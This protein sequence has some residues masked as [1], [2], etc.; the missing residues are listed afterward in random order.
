M[1]K[2][3]HTGSEPISPYNDN[4]SSPGYEANVKRRNRI[5]FVC[6][7]CRRSKTKCDREKPRCGRCIQHGLPC[8]YDVEK[9][10]APRN[11]SKD[12]TISR[13]EKD[14]EY[15]KA[16]ALGDRR[17]DVISSK[18]LLDANVNEVEKNGTKKPRNVNSDI[19]NGSD[20]IQINLYKAHPSMIMNRVM[21]R[22]VKPLSENYA[23]TQDAFLSGLIASVFL[24]PSKNTM[25]PA[26]TASASVSR[27]QP[28]V[29]DNVFKLKEILIRQCHNASQVSRIN[30][31]TDRILQNTNSNRNLR[32]GMMP[33][34]NQ[35]TF[36]RH[37]MEDFC[38]KTGEYSDLL[39]DFIKEMESILPPFDIIKN[40]KAHFY[41]NVFPDLPF[42]NRYLFEESLALTLYPDEDN[43]SKVKIR[44]GNS[45]LRTKMENLSILLVILK[46]SYIS[47]RLMEEGSE[48]F[49]F[50]LDRDVLEKY[51]IS[52]DAVVLAQSCLS[53][54][55]LFA[56][57]NENIITCLLYIWS[58]FVYSPEEGD[59]FLEHPTDVLSGLIVMLATSIGLHRDPS[60]FPQLM[61]ASMTDPSILNH[62]RM[63]WVGITTT[64]CFE[65]SLKG[66]HPL[67]LEVLMNQ[68]VDIRD[69]NAVNIYLERVKKDMITPNTDFL[70]LHECCFKRS[71][72]ALLISDLD[73]LSLT[74]DGNFSLKS[75]EGL[76]DKIENFLDDNFTIRDL[77]KDSNDSLMSESWCNS[78][79][80]ASENSL[81]LHSIIMSKLMILRTSM[82][83]FFHFE[84]LLS[85]NPQ[86]MQFY[87]KYFLRVCIDTLT[88]VN[89]ITKFFNDGYA[90]CLLP[91]NSYNIMKVTQLALSSTCFGALGI[92]M[93]IEL[94]G[95]SL[96]SQYQDTNSNIDSG[97]L[98]ENNQKMELLSVLKKA[99]EIA[100]E[101]VYHVASEHLRFTYFSVF[102]MLALFDVIIQR[103]KKGELWSGMLRLQHVDEMNP[104]LMKALSMTLCLDPDKK[105]NIINKLKMKNHLISFT[106]NDLNEIC[107]KVRDLQ[108]ENPNENTRIS[109]S[110]QTPARKLS[111]GFSSNSLFGNLEKLSSAAAMSQNLDMQSNLAVPDM[112][113]RNGTDSSEAATKNENHAP[114][115]GSGIDLD[116][117]SEGVTMDFPGLFGGLDLFDYDFLFTNEI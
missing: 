79:H 62:R 48:K 67:S 54:E 35:S 49:S 29:T 43:P 13:L 33:T 95:N 7:A 86:L 36:D 47:L 64:I 37:Y 84:S 80:H 100:L 66:R 57:A 6:Q 8:V 97:K 113:G 17:E 88:L 103:M 32:M 52:N 69:P 18:R 109:T 108:Q 78:K 27:A 82:A 11:P 115:G 110:S 40:Y 101:K 50:C 21:K 58:F 31:F 22:E 94:A 3:T 74:Y 107:Q 4:T 38:P 45:R 111:T 106:V 5:S 116:I 91:S 16:K 23:I 25:I 65:S 2:Q 42:L 14:V 71:R 9:Q 34:A 41:E 24:D 85:D 98:R 75:I 76:R 87:C 73:R 102:K 93:R 56:C 90:A 81:A 112:G 26:L 39:K 19:F 44:L 68:F 61:D 114:G 55:N 105:Q 46:L 89:Y 59:F 15:W 83:L 60:D 72:L 10:P 92:I 30:E 77:K 1:L 70:R 20:D 28:S 63:L 117:V 51:P 104:R 53:A 99:F 96:F 12:A